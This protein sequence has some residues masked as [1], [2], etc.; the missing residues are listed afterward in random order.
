VNLETRPCQV[1]VK[2]LSYK[3]KV[4]IRFLYFLYKAPEDLRNLIISKKSQDDFKKEKVQ[5][6]GRKVVEKESQ[7]RML[8]HRMLKYF[9]AQK[10]SQIRWKIKPD[11]SM[12]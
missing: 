7:N 10:C 9:T 4:S 3:G 6:P 1:T 11:V 5:K 2:E 8:W 12:R